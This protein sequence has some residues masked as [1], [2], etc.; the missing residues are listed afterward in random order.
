MQLWGVTE[1]SLARALADWGH[2][3]SAVHVDTAAS[4][5]FHN[6]VTV[7]DDDTVTI[8]RESARL[9]TRCAGLRVHSRIDQI[10]HPEYAAQLLSAIA[11]VTV[12]TWR[13]DGLA[14][15]PTQ[16]RMQLDLDQ[17]RAEAQLTE[18]Q[19]D[20]RPLWWSAA[21]TLTRAPFIGSD[22]A[23]ARQLITQVCPR[24]D[25]LTIPTKAT[26]PIQ[27]ALIAYVG[28]EAMG[29]FIKLWRS[30]LACPDRHE[31]ITEYTTQWREAIDSYLPRHEDTEAQ[32]GRLSAV[33]RE[34]IDVLYETERT[35]RKRLAALREQWMKK[36]T[37]EVRSDPPPLTPVIGSST[38]LP[39][40]RL[41]SY[42][43]PT[44][45]DEAQRRAMTEALT[46][47]RTRQPR[48]VAEPS[49]TP[50]GRA[51]PR[52]LVRRAAQIAG[53]KTVTAA[54]WRRMQPEIVTAPAIAVAAVFDV[55]ASMRPWLAS[56]T[57][58]MWAV[59]CAAHDVGGSASVWG[60]GG[61][62]F[63]VIRPGTAPA[64][65][66]WIDSDSA[67]SSGYAGA[68]RSATE[69][70]GMLSSHDAR[71]LVVLTDGSLPTGEQRELQH[72]VTRL[73]AAGVTVMWVL[74]REATGKVVPAGATVHTN[75]L[76]QMFPA[77]V[78]EVLVQTVRSAS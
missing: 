56:A 32:P 48:L 14:D 66:P 36:S 33:A 5:G 73:S 27:R 16:R 41:V 46:V 13:R 20:L 11:P 62:Q 23:I 55:S 40:H 25:S 58:L 24:A 52:E 59:A 7:D 44:P 61:D 69:R 47:A 54:P 45:D 71:L 77:T 57:S 28:K 22:D 51:D 29:E 74:T 21:T 8:H 1:E 18:Q 60:F 10:A 37:H 26:D 31:L 63:E 34:V 6:P 12:S 42:R 15:D 35:E 72:Y 64:K 19:P 43:A 67:G 68:I 39:A 3:V 70:L 78:R 65:V 30:I 2:S 49:R 53:N 75:V 76:P 17:V 4:R 50:A 38:A 9:D